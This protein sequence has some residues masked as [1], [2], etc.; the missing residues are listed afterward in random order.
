VFYILGVV[1]TG[2][3]EAPVPQCILI[4]KINSG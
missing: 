2:V 4:L 1:V 3:S